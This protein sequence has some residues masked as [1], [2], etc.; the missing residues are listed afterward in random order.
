MITEEEGEPQ[1]KDLKEMSEEEN[2]RISES[3]VWSDWP[4]VNRVE[5]CKILNLYSDFAFI[6]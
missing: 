3:E 1:D 6:R 5:Y 2:E 4:C